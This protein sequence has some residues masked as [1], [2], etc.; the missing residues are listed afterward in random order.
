VTPSFPREQRVERLVDASAIGLGHRAHHSFP[1]E[2]D[3]FND[4]LGRDVAD[5]DVCSDA[6][7]SQRE[8]VLREKVG[9]CGRDAAS[10]CM[11][12][13]EVADF[14]DLPLGIEMVERPA[15]DN[16]TGPDVDSGECR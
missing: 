16:V 5:V 7:D 3:A 15:A 13:D 4:A 12:E 2:A 8:R 1:G 6:L 10:P 9:D 11:R 14:D